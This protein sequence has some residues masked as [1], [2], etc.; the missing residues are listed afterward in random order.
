MNPEITYDSTK[1]KI[2]ITTDKQLRIKV[3]KIHFGSDIANL[4]I[5]TCKD[6][7]EQ[8][9]EKDFT[10]EFSLRGKS[11]INPNYEFYSFTLASKH[12]NG[13]IVYEY[14]CLMFGKEVQ[15]EKYIEKENV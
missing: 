9:L 15:V 10:S 5:D 4:W 2:T 14:K 3:P 13:S 11:D 8:M 1:F 12:A 6:T 7:Y